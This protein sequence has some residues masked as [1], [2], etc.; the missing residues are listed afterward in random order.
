VTARRITKGFAWNHLYKIVEYGGIN[1]YAILVVRK[2]GPEVGGNYPV[3]LSIS[4][5]LAILSAFAVDG[6]LLRYLPRILKGERQYGEVTV[7]GVRPFLIE[8][9]AFRLFVTVILAALVII[10][11]GIL[12]NYIPTMAASLGTIGRLWPYLVIYLFGQAAVSFSV[13][14]LIGLL[15]VKWVF[16]TSLITRFGLLAIGVALVTTSHLTLDGA[17]ALFSLTALANGLM[18]LYWV[19]RHIEREPSKSLKVEFAH[20][21]RRFSEFIRRPKEIRL[22]ILLPF[23]LYG[24]TTWGNDVLSTVLGR[25]PDILMMRAML[26]E[27]ARDIG[28]YEPAARL[29]LMTEYILLFGLGGTLVSVFSEFAHEDERNATADE[30]KRGRVKYTRLMQARKDV[31]G[32]QTVS[33]AP[34]FAFML[35][36]AP[37]VMNVIYG[38]KFTGAVPMLIASLALQALTVIAFSGGMQ[39][40]SLV[41]IGKERV[42]FVNRLSWGVLNLVLNYFLILYWGGLGATIGTAACNCGACMTESFFTKRWIGSSFQGGRSMAI[43]AI[44]IPSVLIAYYAVNYLAAGIPDVLRLIIAAVIMGALTIGG[45]ILFR[46]PEARQAFEKIRS[47]RR[48]AEP[49]TFSA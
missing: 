35:T 32:Y 48:S 23:M 47:L 25:Q 49:A 44:V 4:S 46:I 17:V 39:I 16:Y 5:T 11:L 27:N 30:K 26:G 42:V 29:A 28:L 6:V 31:T 21:R 24:V 20:F 2:F 43:L 3:F 22:F 40:T 37:L 33:T 12:P 7:E 18:L 13:Y 19:I 14:T 34:M 41:V 1:L 38:P 8:L 45:Y 36:F 10:I 15:Q 9:F